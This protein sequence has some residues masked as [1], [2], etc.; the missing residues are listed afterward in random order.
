MEII[1]IFSQIRDAA[2]T[3][4]LIWKIFANPDTSTTYVNATSDATRCI[5]ETSPQGNFA[6]PGYK[7]RPCPGFAPYWGMH[8]S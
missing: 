5:S 4:R 6:T 2:K 7:E 1:G 8:R 3:Q